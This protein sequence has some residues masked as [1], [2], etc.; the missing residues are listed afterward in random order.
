MQSQNHEMAQSGH[1]QIRDIDYKELGS[2]C[3]DK[4]GRHQMDSML[5]RPLGCKVEGRKP[6]RRPRMKMLDLINEEEN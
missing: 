5:R 1:L 6:Q 2:I 4:N 3:M